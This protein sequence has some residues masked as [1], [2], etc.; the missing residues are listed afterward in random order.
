MYGMRM[1]VSDNPLMHR[2]RYGSAVLPAL[3][4]VKLEARPFKKTTRLIPWSETPSEEYI[5]VRNTRRCKEVLVALGLQDSI[6]NAMD[7]LVTS[8][9]SPFDW[10]TKGKVTNP[11][12]NYISLI[13]AGYREVND[14]LLVVRQQGKRYMFVAM[15]VTS[16]TD[17]CLTDMTQ[18]AVA[19]QR[20]MSHNILMKDPTRWCGQRD[21]KQNDG[22]SGYVGSLWNDGLQWHKKG[23]DDMF[24][25]FK[26]SGVESCGE[27]YNIAVGKTA[28]G[29]TL[30]EARHLPNIHA[31]RLR[32]AQSR[33]LLS[34]HPNLPCTLV[35]AHAIGMSIGF[36]SD[37]HNDSTSSGFTESI[38]YHRGHRPLRLGQG[39]WGFCIWNPCIIFNLNTH[40]S[41]AVYVIGSEPHG[42]LPTG[43]K[44]VHHGGIGQVLLA[45][46][47]VISSRW[48]AP[49]ASAFL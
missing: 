12:F 45:R 32:C 10:R 15:F 22:N 29:M 33:R 30:L 31:M 7:V 8:R 34:V 20:E 48:D 38:S 24:G 47:S 36:G 4:M 25:Y 43:P 18:M 13:K 3:K 49:P 2:R 46:R 40:P 6:C 23:H 39:G 42:S 41:S 16:A 1:T 11:S 9:L 5:P 19:A 26:R 21:N 27:A 37:I 14:S 28:R 35:P 44:H 17:P